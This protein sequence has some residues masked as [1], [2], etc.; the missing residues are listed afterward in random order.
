[1][2]LWPQIKCSLCRKK[3][4][5]W[6]GIKKPLS[7]IQRT[8]SLQTHSPSDIPRT[9]QYQQQFIKKQVLPTSK[10][11]PPVEIQKALKNENLKNDSKSFKSLYKQQYEAKKQD[12]REA[13]KF[14]ND[15]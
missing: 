8:N 4:R 7:Q 10:I 15:P 3:V 11:E 9:S 14:T 1:M 13:F 5:I 12:K 6:R 2:A